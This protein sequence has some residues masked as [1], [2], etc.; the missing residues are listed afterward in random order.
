MTGFSYR[1]N[2]FGNLNTLLNQALAQTSVSISIHFYLQPVKFEV[3]L[4]AAKLNAN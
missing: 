1:I 3:V 4:W 2:L